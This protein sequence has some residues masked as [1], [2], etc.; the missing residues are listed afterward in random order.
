MAAFTTSDRLFDYGGPQPYGAGPVCTPFPDWRHELEWQKT[1]H[2]LGRPVDIA[3]LFGLCDRYTE[4]EDSLKEASDQAIE[5]AERTYTDM[6]DAIHEADAEINNKI[7]TKLAEEI[8]GKLN[9]IDR[10]AVAKIVKQV[11][12]DL[13]DIQKELQRSRPSE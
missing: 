8:L 11:L 9:R 2:A 4:I 1:Q 5:E 13:D 7:R 12:H 6:R 10:H 3:A